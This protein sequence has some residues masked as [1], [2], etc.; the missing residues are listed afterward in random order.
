[1]SLRYILQSSLHINVI[2]C[3]HYQDNCITLY[4]QLPKNSVAF[5]CMFVTDFKWRVSI[6]SD[7][8]G[9]FLKGI[10][11]VSAILGMNNA[12]KIIFWLK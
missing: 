4:S 1:M 3:D 7:A 2:E 11:V 6:V 9:V 5:Y 8:L 12:A 10:L